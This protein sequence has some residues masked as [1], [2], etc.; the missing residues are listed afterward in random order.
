MSFKEGTAL[1]FI[2]TRTSSPM[3]FCN[4]PV[5]RW[6]LLIIRHLPWLGEKLQ[7]NA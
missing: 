6:S 7:G 3:M 1:S 4:T 5:H 2:E